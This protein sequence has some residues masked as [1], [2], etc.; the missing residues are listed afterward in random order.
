MVHCSDSSTTPSRDTNGAATIFRKLDLLRQAASATVPRALG[1]GEGAAAGGQGTAELVERLGSHPVQP[2]KL[3]LADLGEL[4]QSRV[5]G[6][7]KRAACRTGEIGWEVACSL[8]VLLVGHGILLVG[9]CW[10]L[11]VLLPVLRRGAGELIVIPSESRRPIQGPGLIAWSYGVGAS[12]RPN[13]G[14][15]RAASRKDV[16]PAIRPSATSTTTSAHGTRAPPGPVG[17]YWAN[18]GDPLAA[19]GT[20]REPLHGRPD[21]SSAWW[22]C[23]RP[24]SHHPSGGIDTVA[25]SC[26]SATSASTS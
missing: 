7:G 21:P 12:G 1:V 10:R 11:V 18:A 9:R 8:L 14:N 4:L 20:R 19:T 26:S 15:R 13:S 24:R 25:S 23:A 16:H 2:P 6:R 3:G 17:V 22:I 5:P